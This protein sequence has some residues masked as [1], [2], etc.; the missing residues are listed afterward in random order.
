MATEAAANRLK[1][2]I[3]QRKIHD[4]NFAHLR[5]EKYEAAFILPRGHSRV[6]FLTSLVQ[7]INKARESTRIHTRARKHTHPRHGKE[8]TLVGRTSMRESNN[9]KTQQGRKR[10]E[11]EGGGGQEAARHTTVSTSMGVHNDTH[12]TCAREREENGGRE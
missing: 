1:W 5:K 2:R 9:N 12:L 7:E 3:S 8:A 4:K 10:R 11:E 6:L